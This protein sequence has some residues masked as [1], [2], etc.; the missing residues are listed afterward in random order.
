[1]HDSIIQYRNHVNFQG[2]A[3]TK[4]MPGVW[5][6]PPKPLNLYFIPIKSS[7]LFCTVNKWNECYSFL[8]PFHLF[9]I[10]HSFYFPVLHY[11][12]PYLSFFLRTFP[13]DLYLFLSFMTW[14]SLLLTRREKC[15]QLVGKV[16]KIKVNREKC[17]SS[18]CIRLSGLIVKD[19]QKVLWLLRGKSEFSA[20]FLT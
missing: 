10:S 6:V 15:R 13:Y 8:S 2:V 4:L 7:P 9:I 18:L 19:K 17:S 12:C 5:F 20:Q 1:M 14:T 3:K 16:K 11:F